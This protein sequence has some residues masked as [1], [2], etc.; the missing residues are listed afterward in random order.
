MQFKHP[1]ILYFLLALLIPILIHLFQ[2]QRFVKVP[3]TNVAFLKTLELQSR[4]SSRLKKWLTLLMRLLALAALI[5]AF[6][7]PFSA[8]SDTAK[9]W[10]TI[11]VLD[12][13]ISM[14]AEEEG[15]ELLRKSVQDL[16]ENLPDKGTFSLFTQN[17]V[18][19]NLDKERFKEVVKSVDYIGYNQSISQ[20]MLRIQSYMKRTPSVQYAVLWL[21]DLQKT[22]DRD[23]LTLP[24]D[25]NL[26]LVPVSGLLAGDDFFNLSID[27]VG[28]KQRDNHALTLEV[29]IKNTGQRL[30]NV[31]LSAFQGDI[32]LGKTFADCSSDNTL[33]NFNL[34]LTEIPETLR[35]ELDV[36]D[37][38]HFDNEYFIALG[39]TEK[40]K[41]LDVSSHRTFVQRILTDENFDY[42]RVTPAMFPY[43]RL[44]DYTVILLN[45]IEGLSREFIQ[46]IKKFVE[47]GGSVVYIPSPKASPYEVNPLLNALQV[48][49][50]TALEK[51]SLLVTKIHYEHELFRGVFERQVN[52]FQYPLVKSYLTIPSSRALPILSYQNGQVFLV[53][54]PYGQGHFY[55]FFS[56]LNHSN[57]NF[58]QAPLVVPVFYKMAAMSNSAQALS[59]RLGQRHEVVLP[60]EV[61]KEKVLTLGQ[62]DF[63]VIPLQIIKPKE[64]TLT[65]C[66]PQKVT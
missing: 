64:I 39:Q 43:D 29:N 21:T 36:E 17:E 33:V 27:T 14:Q 11:V 10:E 4:R 55:A 45:E 50:V 65:L 23:V 3:F 7:Q 22:D 48:G 28:V 37:Y 19:E 18:F 62:N 35:L 1:E 30:E 9:P 5:I 44:Q 51:D 25:M 66:N 41:V 57:S 60:V 63:S 58:T 49:E 16:L 47:T 15:A 61:A 52:N 56:A 54:K 32:L 53:D 42:N 46:T 24:E 20:L 40:V 6:A 12:N 31:G 13:S 2:L 38:Y 34:N 8:T 26:T 59:Y